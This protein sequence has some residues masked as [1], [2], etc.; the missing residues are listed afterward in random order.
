VALLYA[1]Q[2]LVR[3]LARYRTAWGPRAGARH[4]RPASAPWCAGFRTEPVEPA[5]WSD[6][7]RDR[8]ALL[9]ALRADLEQRGM[10][11]RLDSGWDS[12]DFELPGSR[13]CRV[14]LCTVAEQLD[15]GR[16]VIRCRVAGSWTAHAWF[17]FAVLA[18]CLL[19]ATRL[20]APDHP[21]AWLLIGVAGVPAWMLEL[22]RLAA[23]RALADRVGEAG[24]KVGFVPLGTQP[25]T[26]GVR[27]QTR[28]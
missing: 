13:W 22:Q 18:L 28:R 15:K 8:Y 27:D 25:P 12:H 3:G 11:V 4:L 10:S 2:P 21:W 19:A 6:G 16:Q 14:R 20:L 17:L 26:S 24:E 5:F 23:E 1:L 9:D 7:T